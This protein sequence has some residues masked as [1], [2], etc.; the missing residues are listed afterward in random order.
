MYQPD[1][2]WGGLIEISRASSVVS[3]LHGVIHVYKKNFFIRQDI[4]CNC[5][6]NV[7]FFLFIILFIWRILFFLPYY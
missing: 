5:Y 4:V 2:S 1:I 3:E 6:D 7:F